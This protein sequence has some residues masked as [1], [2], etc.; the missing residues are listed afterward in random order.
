LGVEEP[1]DGKMKEKVVGIRLRPVREQLK[2]DASRT[3]DKMAPTCTN[4]I[5]LNT[6]QV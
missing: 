6:T 4:T 3:L 2:I 1:K 5:L